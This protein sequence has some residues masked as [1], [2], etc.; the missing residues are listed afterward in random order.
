MSS[1][2]IRHIVVVSTL[3]AIL[4]I[5]LLLAVLLIHSSIMGA[6]ASQSGVMLI[7]HPQPFAF[8]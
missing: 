5:A 2:L 8:A 6:H 3:V 7:A 4:C 1:T